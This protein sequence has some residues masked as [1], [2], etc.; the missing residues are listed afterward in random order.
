MPL[1]STLPITPLVLGLLGVPSAL[2]GSSGGEVPTFVYRERV[3]QLSLPAAEARAAELRWRPI[4]DQGTPGTER[5]R[6]LRLQA[7]SNPV[8]LSVG[9]E[10]AH[11]IELRHE[12][13][14]VE[15]F[16]NRGA[17]FALPRNLRIDQTQREFGLESG[18]GAAR[19]LVAARGFSAVVAAAEGE[20]RLEVGR[21]FARGSGRG[22]PLQALSGLVL[23]A[24]GSVGPVRV[25]LTEKRGRVDRYFDYE[26]DLGAEFK[27]LVIPLAR[28][29]PR[30]PTAS[31][32]P[33]T[34]YSVSIRALN[35]SR[36]GG[37]LEVDLIGF[38]RDVPA[39]R[40]PTR[41]GEKIA[42]P[43][44]PEAPFPSAELH[45]VDESGARR[46][47]VID[48]SPLALDM[49]GQIA[50]WYCYEELN[51]AKVCDPADAPA[52]F[53]SVPPAPGRRLVVDD[54]SIPI[55]VTR[56]REPVEIFVSDPYLLERPLSLRKKASA[57]LRLDDAPA[58]AY[59]GLRVPLPP[60]DPSFRTLELEFEGVEGAPHIE[61][62]LRTSAGAEPKLRLADYLDGDRARIPLEAFSAVHGAAPRRGRFGRPTDVTLALVP[63]TNFEIRRLAFGWELAP[64]L[65]AGFEGAR[66]RVTAL[67]GR[68]GVSGTGAVEVR[69]STVSRGAGQT[70]RAD[71]KRSGGR[72]SVIVA[73][74][75]GPV[76]TEAYEHLSF[77]LLDQSRVAS[78]QV[79]L[80]GGKASARIA[81]SPY[82]SGEPGLRGRVRIPLR[83]FGRA[84]PRDRLSQLS[85][86]FEGAEP[87]VGFIELDDV[88]F[89]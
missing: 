31:A 15:L 13:G 73:L 19:D 47:E 75:M 26:L 86:V 88:R 4:S 83:D 11:W 80:Q 7:G 42:V 84:L 24:G 62:G 35:P 56:F 18:L 22:L 12:G 52:S 16:A 85:L 33:R 79:L 54:F 50:A 23:V 45:V 48:R 66:G 65:V 41:Q 38:V 5:R 59:V 44:V 10:G 87:G 82:V 37:A 76:N 49:L 71:F 14:G 2:A 81:L 39:F 32:R 1:R 77:T 20:G 8:E 57:L 40:A 28:L 74:G 67:G 78:P 72:S 6:R 55:W 9:S 25:T 43:G 29:R 68:V 46:V 89:E 21:T 64:L 27:R 30:E 17:W 69:S 3:L 58:G 61:V 60:L 63:H 36:R 70:L 51:G 34:A 53:H